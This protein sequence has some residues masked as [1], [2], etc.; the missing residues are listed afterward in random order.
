MFQFPDGPLRRGQT[1]S[2]K[3]A[4]CGKLNEGQH[5]M[6]VSVPPSFPQYANFAEGSDPGVQ[7]AAA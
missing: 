6:P 5:L 3:S 4:Y 1:P 7:W 2:A